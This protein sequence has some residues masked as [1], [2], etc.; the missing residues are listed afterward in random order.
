VRKICSTEDFVPEKWSR[1]RPKENQRIEYCFGMPKE[2]LGQQLEQIRDRAWAARK[3]LFDDKTFPAPDEIWIS[4][5]MTYWWES[6]RDVIEECQRVFP[7]AM[8]RVG[9]IY[10]T[11]APEHAMTRLGLHKPLHLQG[12]ELDPSDPKQQKRHL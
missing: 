10:P 6:T 12:R 8:I 5:I 4:S 1:F 7:K 9:G 2:E 11:L 3:S